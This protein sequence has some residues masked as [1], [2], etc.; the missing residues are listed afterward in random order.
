MANSK[1]NRKEMLKNIGIMNGMSSEKA[2]KNANNYVKSEE[3][4][5]KELRRKIREADNKIK[6]LNQKIKEREEK[7]KWREVLVFYK[8]D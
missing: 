8:M 7:I 6:I 5:K 4:E 2:A 1:E 3:K